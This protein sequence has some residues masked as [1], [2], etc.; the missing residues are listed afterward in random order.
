MYDAPA[1][2]RSLILDLT[3]RVDAVSRGGVPA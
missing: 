1:L 2:L 3:G